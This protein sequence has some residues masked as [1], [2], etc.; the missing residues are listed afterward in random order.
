MLSGSRIS[1]RKAPES[2]TWEIRDERFG[3]CSGMA[4]LLMEEGGSGEGIKGQEVI[5][6]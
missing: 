3:V 2:G 6:S 4:V 5:C 1:V